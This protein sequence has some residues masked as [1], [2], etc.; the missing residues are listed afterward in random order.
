MDFQEI[1]NSNNHFVVEKMM[2]VGEKMLTWKQ[3]DLE[4]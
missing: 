2:T 3:N 1:M 4:R